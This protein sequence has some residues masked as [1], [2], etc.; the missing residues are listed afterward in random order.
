MDSAN[1]E[2]EEEEPAVHK[3]IKTMMRDLFNKLDALSNF[4]FTPK[5]ALPELRIV[6]N[7]PAINMEEVAPVT[8]TEASLLAPEEI[9][10]KPKGDILGN[11]IEIVKIKLYFKHLG[12]FMN[13]IFVIGNTEKTKTDKNRERRKKKLKQKK[14]KEIISKNMLSNGKAK[15]KVKM[16]EVLKNRNTQKVHNLK[17]IISHIYFFNN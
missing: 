3:E 14:H 7:L 16:S 6:N 15:G 13:I 2:K 10:N 12:C 17:L 9:G 4:H 8:A 5:P 11:Y 1:V